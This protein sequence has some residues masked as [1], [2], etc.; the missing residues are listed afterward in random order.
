MADSRMCTQGG[1][2]IH[3]M[4]ELSQILGF[5]GVDKGGL[6]VQNSIDVKGVPIPTAFLGLTFHAHFLPGFN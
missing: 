3:M 2:A 5:S 1:Q 6:S 4:K